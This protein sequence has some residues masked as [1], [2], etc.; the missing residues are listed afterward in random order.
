VKR[1]LQVERDEK[2]KDVLSGRGQVK[3]IEVDPARDVK[4]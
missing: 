4:I 1:I 3:A 2:K